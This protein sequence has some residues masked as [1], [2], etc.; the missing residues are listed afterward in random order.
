ML[1][2]INRLVLGL[3][4]I[5]IA[6][7]SPIRDELEQRSDVY[8]TWVY[9]GYS[10]DLDC[11]VYFRDQEFATGQPGVSFKDLGL[12]V[13]KTNSG[14]CGTPPISYHEYEGSWNFEGES[15]IEIRSKYWGGDK[16]CVLEILSLTPDSLF[17][18][19]DCTF[20]AHTPE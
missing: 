14:W 4:L 8:G 17:V 18:L 5:L 15:F 19:W 13:E 10:T 11:S 20:N 9:D 1:I 12:F 2:L 16:E 6:C 3:L 7:D